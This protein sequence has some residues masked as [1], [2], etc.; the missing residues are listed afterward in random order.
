MRDDGALGFR[1]WASA[2]DPLILKPNPTS[3][4]SNVKCEGAVQP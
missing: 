1:A 3:N 4:A 2:L